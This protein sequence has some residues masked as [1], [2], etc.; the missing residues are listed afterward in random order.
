MNLEA[1]RE[2]GYALLA[3]KII[4]T[5]HPWIKSASSILEEYQKGMAYE[6]FGECMLIYQ[7]S[8]THFNVRVAIYTFRDSSIASLGISTEKSGK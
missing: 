8:T 3:E 2:C 1:A 5:I 4:A 7:F 6:P